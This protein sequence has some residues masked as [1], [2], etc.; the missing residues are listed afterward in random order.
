MKMV[1]NSKNYQKSENLEKSRFKSMN[2]FLTNKSA[3]KLLAAILVVASVSVT[4]A[5]ADG[6]DLDKLETKFFHHTYPKEEESKRLERLE[7][8]FF[9]EGKEGTNQERL[10]KI[11][12]LVPDLDSVSLEKKKP[13][14]KPQPNLTRNKTTSTKD[15]VIETTKHKPREIPRADTGTSYPAITAIEK[16]KLGR[17]FEGD[18]VESRL[19]RLEKKIMG[20]VSTSQDFTERMDELKAR[21]GVDIARQAP[22]GTDWAGDDVTI[23]FP[24]PSAN[25]PRQTFSRP[26]YGEDGKTFSGRNLREDMRK[27]L[28]SRYPSSTGR[29]YYGMS[30]SNTGSSSSGTYGFGKTGSSSSGS[31]SGANDRTKTAYVPPSNGSGYPPVAPPIAKSKPMGLNKKVDLLEGQ[32]FGRNFKN[33]SL[34]DR[35]SRLEKTVFPSKNV[36]RNADLRNRVDRLAQVIPISSSNL[37]SNASQD[38]YRNYGTTTPNQ[39]QSQ[40]QVPNQISQNQ[41]QPRGSRSGLSKILGAMGNFISGGFSVGSYPMTGNL[42]VDPQT[43]LYLDRTTGNLIDPHTGMVVGRKGLNGYN[44]I[45]PG[46]GFNYGRSFN[47]GFS[48]P[49][50]YNSFGNSYGI[51][52]TGIRFGTGTGFGGMGG[53]WP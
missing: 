18:P 5:L 38:P 12:S 32:I 29:G 20:R 22:P 41:N 46:Y 1:Y 44:R 27:A 7:K 51:G 3:F 28:G 24:T 45:N 8:M 13:K 31:I 42:V 36:K 40:Y 2:S 43:R 16:S 10:N 21:T 35:V 53:M 15:K 11:K 4:P 6:K 17:S 26:K 34:Q 14:A 9:G 37:I 30:G 47:N 25:R 23:N 50:N 52:G 39:N 33:D 19:A 48:S 49:Y